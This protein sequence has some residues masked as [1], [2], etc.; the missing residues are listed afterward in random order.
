MVRF[1]DEEIAAFERLAA[2]EELPL[3]TVVRRAAV[4]S[5]RAALRK[6]DNG[7]R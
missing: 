1:N 2:A 5:A 7:H 6:A 3:A 4:Q